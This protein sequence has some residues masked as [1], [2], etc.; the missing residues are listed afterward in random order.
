MIYISQRNKIILIAHFYKMEKFYYFGRYIHLNFIILFFWHSY[1]KMWNFCK[2][3]FW[4]QAKNKWPLPIEM[5]LPTLQLLAELLQIH[6]RV[7]IKCTKVYSIL[8]SSFI[9]MRLNI[10]RREQSCSVSKEKTNIW[11]T[12]GMLWS[13]KV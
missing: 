3:I 11:V 6:K 1:Y 13:D 2:E 7:S 10:N 5:I 9:D 12:R 4:W 8:V